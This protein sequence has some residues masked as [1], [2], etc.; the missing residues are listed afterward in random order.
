[1]GAV[2][3]VEVDVF[4]EVSAQ[5]GVADVEVAGEVGS[6]AF[7]EDRL[8]E[9]FDVA[10]GLGPAGV[11]AGVADPAVFEQLVE[12]GAKLV[13][14]VGDDAF[15]L[16]TSVCEIFGDPATRRPGEP[17]CWSAGGWAGRWG[18]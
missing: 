9:S 1:V 18:R 7:V 16:P 5:A 10:V 6:P 4:G 3:V 13:A 11:D 17:A 14:I 2:G 8:V 15:Q 12:A